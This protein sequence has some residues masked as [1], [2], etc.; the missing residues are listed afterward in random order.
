MYIFPGWSRVRDLQVGIT[1]E[2]AITLSTSYELCKQ[3]ILAPYDY[4]IIFKVNNN[5]LLKALPHIYLGEKRARR[6]GPEKITLTIQFC[7]SFF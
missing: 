2:K 1:T 7:L 6:Q 3:F 5:A 4:I